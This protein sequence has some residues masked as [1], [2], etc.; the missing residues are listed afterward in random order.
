M[1]LIFCIYFFSQIFNL[2]GVL[3]EK[4]NE[5]LPELNGI[6]WEKVSNKKSLPLKKIIWKSYNNDESLFENEKVNE[7]STTKIDPA[8]KE[9]IFEPL[10]TSAYFLTEIE[11]FLPLNNFLEFGNFQTLIRWKSSFMEVMQKGLD[12]KTLHLFLI[13]GFQILP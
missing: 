10:K 8:S 3:A 1:R 7:D 5:E 11:P 13:M 4:V 2:I 6:K 12:S 9:K